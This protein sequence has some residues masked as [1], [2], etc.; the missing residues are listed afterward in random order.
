MDERD[1]EPE[2][3]FPRLLVDQL[4]AGV[5]ETRQRRCDVVHLIGDVVHP[6][7]AAREEPTD[8]R[9]LLQRLEELDAARADANSRGVHTLRRHRRPMLDLGTEQP[10]VR[11]QRR[12]EIVDR[13]AE[14]VNPPGLHGTML[15]AAS[16]RSGVIR[17]V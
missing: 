8:G 7:T 17:A 4:D 15:T 10:R 3:P 14:V 12:V 9:V 2:E 16:H 1:L 6:G 5:A 11:R 13:D